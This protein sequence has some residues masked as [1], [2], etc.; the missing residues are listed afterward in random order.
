MAPQDPRDRS[1][2]HKHPIIDGPVRG[3]FAVPERSSLSPFRPSAPGHRL[4]RAHAP[5]RPL[6]RGTFARDKRQ[7]SLF[8]PL[9]VPTDASVPQSCVLGTRAGESS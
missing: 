8:R 9:W 3:A 5:G 4:F 6:N 1:A 7:C 2:V